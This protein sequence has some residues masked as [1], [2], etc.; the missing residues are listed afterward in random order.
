MTYEFFL[1]LEGKLVD[2]KDELPE[3]REELQARIEELEKVD[4]EGNIIESDED[5]EGNLKYV[6]GQELR[7]LLRYRFDCM[8]I[9]LY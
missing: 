9:C 7:N 6:C 3:I 2:L 5:E 4:E 8:V 1:D